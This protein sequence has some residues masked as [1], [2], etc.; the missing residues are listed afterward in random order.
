MI[1]AD[2]CLIAT[3]DFAGMHNTRDGEMISTQKYLQR[4]ANTDRDK[5]T[6]LVLPLPPRT[7]IYFAV[8]GSNPQAKTGD[9]T[10]PIPSI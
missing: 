5:L 10:A 9:S 2:E 8:W 4:Y 7:R 3:V 1:G 6:V